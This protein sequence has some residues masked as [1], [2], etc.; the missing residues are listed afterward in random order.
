MEQKEKKE[1]AEIIGKVVDEKVTPRLKRLEEKSNEHDRKLDTT[2]EMVAKNSEDIEM[3]KE[4]F[5]DTGY[6]LER[7]ETKLDASIRR[8]DDA[9]VK[10][11][12]L[13]RRVL[14]LESKKS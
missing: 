11:S 1:M 8:Q 4:D 3:L 12:Q 10:T 5:T 7:I 9:S 6:T 14:R 13:Q 2:M